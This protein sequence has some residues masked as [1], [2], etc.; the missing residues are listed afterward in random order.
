MEI[1]ISSLRRIFWWPVGSRFS[2]NI[3]PMTYKSSLFLLIF[4]PALFT[5]V[6]MAEPGSSVVPSL[7]KIGHPSDKKFEW[8]CRQIKKGET[9]ESIFGNRWI[10]V[11]RFNRIDRRH[12]YPGADLKVP[13]RLEDI[14]DFTPMPKEYPPAE[15]DEK[16]I[17]VD[18]S[19]QFLGAYEYGRL[20]FSSPVATGED[21]HET[22]AGIFRI[23][24]ISR[25]HRSSKYFI[26]N[27]AIPYPMNFGLRFFVS[28]GEVS[29]WIHGRD[30]PGYP[31]SHGCLGLYD[32]PM[33]KKYYG[34]PKDPVLED[35]RILYEWIVG[36]RQDDGIFQVMK[37]GPSMEIVG[38]A[39]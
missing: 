25:N 31:A 28:K 11:A 7:C 38:K 22:P 34:Y 23:T 5:S 35:A 32:E 24:A 15:K 1:W 9:L 17:L 12:A 20:V 36:P 6:R 26:E 30:L 21:G 8:E 19:E 16:F 18:L 37:D 10:D 13:L 27:T 29:Y 14:T 4:L 33:Q 3:N 2:G 39:P